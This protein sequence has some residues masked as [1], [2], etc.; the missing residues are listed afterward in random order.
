MISPSPLR[1]PR[2][3]ADLKRGRD[4]FKQLLQCTA[5]PMAADISAL[6]DHRHVRTVQP[7]SYT[8][9]QFLGDLALSPHLDVSLAGGVCD[10]A[11]FSPHFPMLMIADSRSVTVMYG[12]MPGVTTVYKCPAL[13]LCDIPHCYCRS[14]LLKKCV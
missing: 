14:V 7:T 12:S 10:S 8:N 5:I 4:F 13:A 2:L 6:A 9:T 3:C 1:L 11:I